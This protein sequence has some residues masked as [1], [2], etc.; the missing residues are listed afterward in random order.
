MQKKYEKE[1]MIV[2]FANCLND[3]GIADIDVVPSKWIY[4]NDEE[5]TCKTPYPNP[6]YDECTCKFLHSRVKNLLP[7][8]SSWPSWPIIIKGSASNY[9]SAENRLQKLKEEA[10]AFSTDV[11]GLSPANKAEKYTKKYRKTALRKLFQVPVIGENSQQN[12][13]RNGEN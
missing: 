10:F 9:K 4:Y 12:P 5:E 7:P 3:N 1:F 13:K 6:P 11:D 8:L 2:E